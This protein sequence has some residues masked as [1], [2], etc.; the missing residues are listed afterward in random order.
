M[1]LCLQFNLLQ[2][3]SQ[4]HFNLQIRLNLCCLKFFK[5]LITKHYYFTYSIYLVTNYSLTLYLNQFESRFNL[6]TDGAVLNPNTVKTNVS[7]VKDLNN[8]FFLNAEIELVLKSRTNFGD[9]CFCRL[10]QQ[11]P[12]PEI[13]LKRTVERV[14]LHHYLVV[15]LQEPHDFRAGAAWRQRER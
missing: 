3:R 8:L 12:P 4:L 5:V 14:L 7:F 15:V 13:E 2:Q 11:L 10:L 9:H 6:V 1:I